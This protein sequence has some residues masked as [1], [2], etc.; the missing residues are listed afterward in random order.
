MQ[1]AIKF[2]LSGQTAFFKKP[3][4]NEYAYFTYNNI[5]KIALL[6][7]LGAIIGLRG[8]NQQ[9]KEETYPEFYEK[10]HHLKVAIVPDKSIKGIYAKKIQTFNNSVGYASNEQG[11]NLI[12][13][14]QWL[15][16]PSWTIYFYNDGTVEEKVYDKLKEYLLQ[17]KA[18]YV[19]YLG[20]NDHPATIKEVEEVEL[21]ETKLDYIDSIFTESIKIDDFDSVDEL[22][23]L[24][25][26][27]QPIKLQEE[28]NFYEYESFIYTN[29][30]LKEKIDGYVDGKINLYFF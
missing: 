27:I 25:K 9:K 22:A 12:V 13:R 7:M 16:N 14:E 30:Y 15:E 28:Y 17:G 23:Y 2:K 4:V 29:Y 5:H 21:K 10:L 11:G 6:G 1:K 3:E 26:E 20:K 19:P 24:V 8:Y 18:V